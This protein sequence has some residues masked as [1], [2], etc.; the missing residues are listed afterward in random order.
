VPTHGIQREKE[1]G[2]ICGR[3]RNVLGRREFLWNAHAVGNGVRC[4]MNRVKRLN[5][6]GMKRKKLLLF[7]SRS[8]R[9]KKISKQP[10]KRLTRKSTTVAIASFPDEKRRILIKSGGKRRSIWQFGGEREKKKKFI[11]V[12]REKSP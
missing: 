9:E 2:E 1:E 3:K 10:T 5:R 6:S 4:L 7:M 11:L 12:G 8:D